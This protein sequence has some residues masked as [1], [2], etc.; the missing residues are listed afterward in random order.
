MPGFLGV[1]NNISP[2]FLFSLNL[3]QPLLS[4]FNCLKY[5]RVFLLDLLHV[6]DI[7]TVCVEYAGGVVGGFALNRLFNGLTNLLPS[8]VYFSSLLLPFLRLR[9][10]QRQDVNGYGGPLIAG[11]V[12]SM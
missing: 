6:G 7:L 11:K 1:A 10:I 5:F 2:I 8:P 12:A 3:R 4:F 9:L